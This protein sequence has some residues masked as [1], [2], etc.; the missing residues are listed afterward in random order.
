MGVARV[1]Y[2][3]L[4][5]D[6]TDRLTWRLL[7]AN[8]RELGRGG[9]VYPNAAACH[10]AFA[11]LVARCEEAHPNVTAGLRNSAWSWRLELDGATVA[12]SSR[13]Y[14]RLR[15]CEYNLDRFREALPC[16]LVPTSAGA[17]G[18]QGLTA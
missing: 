6:R 13:T 18:P 3:A 8:N 1:Q 14:Q 11:A 12:A 4:P 7:G 10:D 2:V 5:G 16:A 15:E 17:D 9:V